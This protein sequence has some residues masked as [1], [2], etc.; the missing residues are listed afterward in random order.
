MP[1]GPSSGIMAPDASLL[2]VRRQVAT[3]Q[4]KRASFLPAGSISM[5]TDWKLKLVEALEMTKLPGRKSSLPT[6]FAEGDHTLSSMQSKCVVDGTPIVASVAPVC[7]TTS[8]TTKQ[9]S[10]KIFSPVSSFDRADEEDA[11]QEADWDSDE[12]EDE[13]VANP[14]NFSASRLNPLQLLNRA[15]ELGA[16]S[17]VRHYRRSMLSQPPYSR[18]RQQFQV[19]EPGSGS[20]EDPHLPD[21]YTLSNLRPKPKHGSFAGHPHALLGQQLDSDTVDPRHMSLQH[22]V[23]SPGRLLRDSVVGQEVSTSVSIIPSVFN[24]ESNV[25]QVNQSNLLGR[26]WRK[27]AHL[28][29]LASLEDDEDA[30]EATTDGGTLQLD[31]RRSSRINRLGSAPRPGV[32]RQHGMTEYDPPSI[33]SYLDSMSVEALSRSIGSRYPPST[34]FAPT[35]SHVHMES[36]QRRLPPN[37][38]FRQVIVPNV[39]PSDSLQIQSVTATR[40]VRVQ[41]PNERDISFV[42]RGP[43]TATNMLRAR[44]SDLEDTFSESRFH[45]KYSLSDLSQTEDGARSESGSRCQSR[46]TTDVTQGS[47]Q[48]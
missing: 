46:D 35:D 38:G 44:R 6:G 12:G 13:D 14:V 29:S 11:G 15:M 45:L 42:K 30:D 48:L 10:G 39:P 20:N 41:K 22:I 24:S 23:R 9:S 28:S 17:T 21:G 32:R 2:L 1:T 8:T 25:S 26:L 7:T 34:Q 4:T 43:R 19:G 40:T 18:S 5:V 16:C 3:A 47:I 31:G 33:S 36:P 27:Q 37:T